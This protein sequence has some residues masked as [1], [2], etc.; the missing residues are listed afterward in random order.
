MCVD[1][2]DT[3]SRKKK[4]ADVSSALVT[5]ACKYAAAEGARTRHAC[6]RSVEE[7]LPLL[8]IFFFVSAGLFEYIRARYPF[9]RGI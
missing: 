6:T 3:R 7:L 1:R 5:A 9:R 4:W 2:F 8:S